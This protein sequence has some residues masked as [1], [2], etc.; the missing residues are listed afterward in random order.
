MNNG[1]TTIATLRKIQDS[2]NGLVNGLVDFE[3]ASNNNMCVLN[4]QLEKLKAGTSEMEARLDKM[5]KLLQLIAEKLEVNTD[6]IDE[7]SQATTNN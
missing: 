3:K 5:N 6:G 4:K 7:A 1:D 2:M